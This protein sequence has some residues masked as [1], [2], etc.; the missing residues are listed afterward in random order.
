MKKTL[1]LLTGAVL[2]F[3]L[4]GCAPA[5]TPQEYLDGLTDGF[6][7]YVAASQEIGAAL[8]AQTYDSTGVGSA[9]DALNSI[10]ALSPPSEYAEVHK[11]LSESIKTE[12]EWLDAVEEFCRLGKDD[13]TNT[14]EIEK[15]V[16]KLSEIAENSE[17]AANILNT[18]IVVR[19]DLE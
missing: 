13:P 15:T 14:A 7:E 12:L 8:D 2:L 18:V 9:R 19:G 6:H 5:L 17:F 4:A 10:R 1:C 11:T 3:F 16:Q